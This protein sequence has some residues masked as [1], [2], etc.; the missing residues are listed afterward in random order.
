MSKI[1]FFSVIISLFLSCSKNNNNGSTPPVSS[2]GL[3]PLS[4]GNFWKFTKISYDSITGAPV[5]TIFDEIDIIGQISLNGTTYFQQNQTSIT[6]INAGSFFINLDSNT[7]QKIDSSVSYTFFKKVSIDSSSVDSWA[8]TVTS[9]CK[10]SNHLY[11]FTDTAIINGYN[12][13]RN[14]VDVYDCTGLDFEKWEYYLKPGLGLVR[15]L[16]YVLKNDG[17]FYLQ[18]SEDL[19]SYH[20]N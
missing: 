14:E 5:D 7:L 17:T 19:E 10:G 9:R 6:N 8:D 12:C 18:F 20:T 3:M 15:I 1:I 16:H 4:V 2:N 13:L 11:G